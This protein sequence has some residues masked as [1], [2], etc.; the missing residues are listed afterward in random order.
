LAMI[1]SP[2]MPRNIRF[3]KTKLTSSTPATLENFKHILSSALEDK[4]GTS[5]M[6]FAATHGDKGEK[7]NDNLIAFWGGD[8]MSARELAEILDKSTRPVRLVMTSCYSGG[9]ADVV[10]AGANSERGAPVNLRCGF[11]STSWDKKSS[12]CDPNPERN[13]QED[14][15]VH[16]WHA[17]RDITRDE[18]LIPETK[19]DF[20]HN[21]K[22]SLL[23]AHNYVR[24]H[25]NTVDVPTTTSIRWLQKT[26]PKDG[27]QSA[28]DWP[29]ED[30]VIEHLSRKLGINPNAIRSKLNVM[31]LA[32]DILNAKKDRLLA[33][34]IS[35]LNKLTA[36]LLARWPFLEDPWHLGF[37]K[38]LKRNQEAIE[39]FLNT[40]SDHAELTKLH[41]AI[42]KL[43]LEREK[44]LLEAAPYERLSDAVDN[45][46]MA[47]RLHSEGGGNWA[48]FLRVLGCE[49]SGL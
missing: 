2:N 38:V 45:K 26:A 40:S 13:A 4:R 14:Y 1:L 25:A 27:A 7:R 12:C 49:R 42:N 37:D 15:S 16:F 24:I 31:H 21:G 41:D 30:A 22:I 19:I 35:L 17:V 48:Y 46:M 10:F 9:F 32:I 20:D 29:E 47:E 44:A 33:H 5:L 11:F 3:Q 34:E 6:L 36:Q 28:F 23:E 8:T 18:A 43:E 39:F